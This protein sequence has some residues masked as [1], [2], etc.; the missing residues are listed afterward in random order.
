MAKV[1]PLEQPMQVDADNPQNESDE[2]DET[3]KPAE[4][5]KKIPS[6]FRNDGVIVDNGEGQKED[7]KNIMAR[8]FTKVT[9]EHAAI[10]RELT[11][12]KNIINMSSK[13]LEH[14]CRRN[15][16]KLGAVVQCVELLELTMSADEHLTDTRIDRALLAIQKWTSVKER[17]LNDLYKATSDQI[18]KESLSTV[19]FIVS[20]C[21]NSECRKTLQKLLDI[22]PHA[23]EDN[24]SDQDLCFRGLVFWRQKDTENNNAGHLKRLLMELDKATLESKKQESQSILELKVDDLGLLDGTDEHSIRRMNSIDIKEIL[25]I[26]KSISQKLATTEHRD[27]SPFIFPHDAPGL[28]S[29]TQPIEDVHKRVRTLSVRTAS[30][31]KR[32]KQEDHSDE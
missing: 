32:S 23:L 10:S 31:P 8:H 13:T 17:T 21:V 24:P 9:C 5:K 18:P 27:L 1:N 6:P 22:D 12:L 7:L 14:L 19:Q 15:D 3:D 16:K 26:V 11:T 28:P 4:L 20:K 2:E 29:P 25:E 30:P